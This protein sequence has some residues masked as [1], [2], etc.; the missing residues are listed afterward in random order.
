[1]QW[2]KPI[3]VCMHC[4]LLFKILSPPYKSIYCLE[5]KHIMYKA[6]LQIDIIE[7]SMSLLSRDHISCVGQL[8]CWKTVYNDVWPI[9]SATLW[10]NDDVVKR[11]QRKESRRPNLYIFPHIPMVFFCLVKNWKLIFFLIKV[12]LVHKKHH[13]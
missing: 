8:W 11:I 4:F 12:I 2:C 9:V 6:N 7:E 3:G 5:N 10:G 13:D 1:M